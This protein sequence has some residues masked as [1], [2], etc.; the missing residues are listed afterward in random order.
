V[1]ERTA[2]FSLLLLIFFRAIVF[3]IPFSPPTFRNAFGRPHPE[4]EPRNLDDFTVVSVY[5]EE[6]CGGRWRKRWNPSPSVAM[7]WYR[8]QTVQLIDLFRSRPALWDTGSVHYRNK[9]TKNES[10]EQIS[11]KLKCPKEE[12]AKKICTLRVQF[13]RENVKVKRARENGAVYN[14]KW[15]GYQLLCFLND[16]SRYTS[17]PINN[18]YTSSTSL[19]G[20]ATAAAAA[21]RVPDTMASSS[22][23]AA[24]TVTQNVSIL[25]IYIYMCN[26]RTTL[27]SR[28]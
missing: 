15:F 8:E 26:V 28:Y 6:Y 4:F 11:D 12:I 24:A 7:E 25:F 3:C 22:A 18:S 9:R 23:A 20:N 21:L 2:T 13:S 10:L 27:F 16:Q 19:A 5:H 14:P 1:Y 17:T